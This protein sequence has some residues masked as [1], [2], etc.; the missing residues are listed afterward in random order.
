MMFWNY[1]VMVASL[2]SCGGYSEFVGI[3]RLVVVSLLCVILCKELLSKSCGLS[4]IVI[5]MYSGLASLLNWVIQVFLTFGLCEYL[6]CILI[7]LFSVASISMPYFDYVDVY[8]SRAL[9]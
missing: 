1:V 7:V 5:V 9:S 3:E 2:V 4:H 6:A 8:E